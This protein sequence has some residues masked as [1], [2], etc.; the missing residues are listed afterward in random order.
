MGES[1]EYRDGVFVATGPTSVDAAN[2]AGG[3]STGTALMVRPG[4]D[5]A[6]VDVPGP[7]VGFD[8][9]P[10][11][12]VP[13]SAPAAP[14]VGPRRIAVATVIA[15]LIAAMA[16][17]AAAFG[18]AFGGNGTSGSTPTPSPGS[19]RGALG[20]AAAA[21]TSARS[22]AFT[23]SA[24]QSSPSGTTTLVDGTGAVDLST[25]T[26]R[27]RATVPAL[28]GLVGSA[29]DSIDVIADG[30]TVYLGSPAISSL[31]GGVSWLKATLPADSS[32]A[33]SQTLAVLAD[34]AQLLGLLA[35]VGGHVATTDGVDLHGTSTTE[36]T[37]TV[38]LAELASRAG[39]SG[40]TAVG[41]K[42]AQVLGQLG[43]TSVPITAWVG[44]D[45]YVRQVSASVDLSRATLGSLASDL[46]GAVVGGTLGTGTSGQSTSATTVT[47][48]FSDY[49]APVAVAVPPAS[50]TAD[51]NAFGRTVRGAVSGI[52]HAASAFASKF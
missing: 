24:T 27:L 1:V 31:T 41:A 23:V 17:G 37:T 11:G 45:G 5:L 9:P 10:T 14:A 8:V 51:V 21:S 12:P 2:L 32:N 49:N 7:L 38:T 39:F 13:P 47:V 28:S 36:Y 35:S 46:V 33:D 25:D 30:R 15:S 34:P 48:G 26:G 3:S 44:H 16:F 40:G 4:D 29:N 42:V 6:P 18:G 19:A 50:S 52:A 43:N 22:V 20:A